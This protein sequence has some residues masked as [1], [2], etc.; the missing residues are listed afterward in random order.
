MDTN[1]AT[2]GDGLDLPESLKR[3][4]AK[5]LTKSQIKVRDAAIAR[6]ATPATNSRLPK[7]GL[8][9]AGVAML[10]E[11][12]V[13]KST[14][15]A[16]RHDE[17]AVVKQQERAAK[18]REGR[19]GLITVA[20]IAKE[21]GMIPREARACL[22]AA[23]LTKPAGGWAFDAKDP[24]LA[25]VREV[26]TSGKVKTTKTKTPV[27]PKSTPIP[28]PSETVWSGKAKKVAK[29]KIAVAVSA[30]VAARAEAKKAV[31]A[32]KPTKVPFNAK[33]AAAAKPVRSFATKIKNF[34]EE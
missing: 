16:G 8:E 13:A 10:K 24:A 27:A 31:R 18:V 33:A 29:A 25:K 22:R 5:P 15:D 9:P 21:Y 23:K 19:G 11:A 26:L 2:T 7:G 14:K 4:N 32:K 6:V 12:S 1:G 28:P 3:V 17:R 30:K 34:G 20:S